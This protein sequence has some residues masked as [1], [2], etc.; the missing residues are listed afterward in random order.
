[1]PDLQTIKQRYGIVGRS[2]ALDHAI[3]IAVQVAPTNLSV[4]IQGESG[5]GK[6][7]FSRIIHDTS[8]RKSHTFIAI[9]CGSIPEGTIDSE[10]FGHVKGAFTDALGERDGYFASA[11][12]G[13]LFLDEV[14]ELPLSTQA[15]LLRVLES[16][17]FMKVGSSEVC[18]TDVRI[19]AATN[20]NLQKAIS[21][22]R[23]R[24]DLYYR[25]ATIPIN[26]PP[27][28]ERGDDIALLFRKFAADMAD[29]YRIAPVTLTDDGRQLLLR[30][31]WPGNIRQLRNLTE[32][33]SIIAPRR[34]IDAPTLRQFG[35]TDDNAAGTGLVLSGRT[36]DH[37]HSYESEREG[38]LHIITTLG[39]E[40]K[41][42]K[43]MLNKLSVNPYVQHTAP[44]ETI[45][46]EQYITPIKTTKTKKK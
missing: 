12:G 26:I 15:R 31:K 5:V 44:I 37:S 11:N 1:M 29:K 36:A 41:D 16:G 42:I 40:I 6:E 39:K 7:N 38:L 35:I 19:V 9:N 22:G 4:L 46:D 27:L 13:T 3:D 28:R 17:E 2:E 20:V 34:D 30:Y 32:Q 24:E 18:H 8:L 45:P 10:L 23:F 43:S 21:E 25:L 33:L 14:G